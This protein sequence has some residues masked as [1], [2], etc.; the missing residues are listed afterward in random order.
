MTQ[1]NS[2]NCVIDAVQLNALHRRHDT[3]NNG[4]L[5]YRTQCSVCM[6][7]VIWLSPLILSFVILIVT[8]NPIYLRVII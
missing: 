8:I 7:S 1:Q 6:L 5:H 3:Q 4:N 2:S